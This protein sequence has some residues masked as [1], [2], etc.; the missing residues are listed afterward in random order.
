MTHLSGTLN[1]FTTEYDE[2]RNVTAGQGSLS[3]D[4]DHVAIRNIAN[5][6]SHLLLKFWSIDG[7]ISRPSE[8]VNYGLASVKNFSLL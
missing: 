3:Q 7:S 8:K 6:S 2:K 5:V 4:G 1:N